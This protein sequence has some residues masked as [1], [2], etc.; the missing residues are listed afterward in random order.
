MTAP[1]TNTIKLDPLALLLHASGPVRLTVALLVVSGAAVWLIFVLKFLQTARVRRAERAFEKACHGA[2]DGQ[3]LYAAAVHHRAS[4]GARIVMILG[5]RPKGTSEGRLRAVAERAL[6]DERTR[7]T[8]LMSTLGSIAAAAPFV[9]LFGTV[10]GIMD[11]FIRIGQEKSASLPVVAPAIGEALITTAIGLA[12]AIPAVVFYNAI[13][14]RVSQLIEE[15][16]ASVAE[17]VLVFAHHGH[18]AAVPLTRPISYP[19]PS[20]GAAWNS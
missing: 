19:P 7:A 18:D 17:W 3:E 9:G 4:P 16:E 14:K 20:G 1:D 15:I 6:V 12:A 13:D 2:S 11:A 5:E 10:Y 8:T